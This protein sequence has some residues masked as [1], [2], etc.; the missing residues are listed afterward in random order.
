MENKL[1]P[2]SFDEFIGQS[3]IVENLKI[4]IQA[5]LGQH[6]MLDHVLLSGSSGLGK[7]TL[8]T[9]I[10]QQ[11][12]SNLKIINAATIESMAQLA[13]IFGSINAGDVIFIDEIHALNSKCE[14]LLYPVL[15]DY[16]LDF[17]VSYAQQTKMLNVQLPPFTLIGATT[18]PFALSQPLF[19][20][21]PIHFV[22][23]TYSITEIQEIIARNSNILGLNLDKEAMQIL[24]YVGRMT[25]RLINGH[26]RRLLDYQYVYKID[27]IT[28]EILDIYLKNQNLTR[29]GLNN[30]DCAYLSCLFDANGVKGLASLSLSL[31]LDANVI[32]EQ[33][34]PYL[35]RLK[36]IELTKNGRLLTSLGKSIVECLPQ[37]K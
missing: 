26:L 33:I 6:R 24:A 29:Q 10:A 7:T 22:L 30:N 11:F 20:R 36:Y 37:Y 18:K 14:E 2:A 3:A 13:H 32:S 1:T 23:E 35:I 17:A 31:G 28:T 8:S 19:N 9:I 12:D 16:R 27:A 4:Y 34:E 15:Q 25:P 21:F 5:A